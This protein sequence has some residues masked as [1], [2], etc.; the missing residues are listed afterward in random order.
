MDPCFC[1]TG[2]HTQTGD[3]IPF[4]IFEFLFARPAKEGAA[5]VVQAAAA[6][7]ESHGKY[8]RVGK[9]QQ[10]APIV[11]DA[12]KANHIW[13]HLCKRLEALQPGVLQN[14]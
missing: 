5:L 1:S 12:E 8:F 3:S 2:L 11:Q 6:G 7:E 4:K 13:D 10:Y 14:I 9:L